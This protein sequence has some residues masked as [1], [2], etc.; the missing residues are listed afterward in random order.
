MR[1]NREFNAKA[2]TPN[3]DHVILANQPGQKFL[4]YQAVAQNYILAISPEEDD[5][6]STTPGS[7]KMPM[8]MPHST[9]TTRSEGSIA[10]AS[11]VFGQ[12]AILDCQHVPRAHSIDSLPAELLTLDCHVLAMCP[13]RK[14]WRGCICLPLARHAFPTNIL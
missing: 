4:T 12:P 2:L 6:L 8:T 13:I 7:L 10:I 1:K 5:D 11:Q 9:M 14:S 3:R